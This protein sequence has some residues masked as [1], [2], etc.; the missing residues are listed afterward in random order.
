MAPAP[1][2]LVMTG[3]FAAPIPM[4]ASPSPAALLI[5]NKFFIKTSLADRV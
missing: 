1:P 2:V 4:A 5:E 3:A